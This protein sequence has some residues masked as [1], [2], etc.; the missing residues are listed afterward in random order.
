MLDMSG[1]TYLSS[2]GIIRDVAK[3][4]LLVCTPCRFA[5]SPLRLS[6]HLSEKHADSMSHH[7]R[8]EMVLAGKVLFDQGYHSDVESFKRSSNGILP[9]PVPDIKVFLDGIKCVTCGHIQSK[10]DSMRK[11]LASHSIT[12]ADKEAFMKH[13]VSYQKIFSHLL[14]FT[15]VQRPLEVTTLT[16]AQ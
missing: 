10:T 15:E 6:S 16:T 9:D 3:H 1:T 8:E 13:G 12:S 11:H 5:V 7:A 4:K 2:A 14:G